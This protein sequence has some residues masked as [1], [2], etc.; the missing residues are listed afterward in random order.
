MELK[1]IFNCYSDEREEIM[2]NL[3]YTEDVFGDKISND[4][5]SK[6]TQLTKIG[7]SG[8]NNVSKNFRIIINLFKLQNEKNIDT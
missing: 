8:R 2:K 7:F 1:K 5:I 6:K 3:Q 4:S